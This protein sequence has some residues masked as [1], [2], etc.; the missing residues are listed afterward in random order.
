MDCR[1]K[2]GNDDVRDRSRD[3]YAS[4]A[5]LPPRPKRRFAPRQQRV[6]PKSGVRFSDEITRRNE[7]GEA[8]KGACQ[9]LPRTINKRYACR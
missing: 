2:P 5:C 7:G 8:P 6:I 3:A 1:V 4:E 9:P